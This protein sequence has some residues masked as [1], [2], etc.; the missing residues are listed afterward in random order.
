MLL[1][2]FS[3]AGN[4]DWMFWRLSLRFL[5]RS[6]VG[7]DGN[8]AYRTQIAFDRFHIIEGRK[9]RAVQGLHR[10]VGTEN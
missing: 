5:F 2:I 3:L 1:I 9:Q 7:A 8:I 10:D 6:S 4:I